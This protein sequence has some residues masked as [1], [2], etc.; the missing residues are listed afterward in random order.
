[1]SD[2][3][4][5]NFL[6]K[7]KDEWLNKHMNPALGE[8]EIMKLQQQAEEKFSLE[9][10]LANASNRANSRAIT[11]HPSK[12]SH[13]STGIGK[14]NHHNFT[15][16]TPIIS[17]R[18]RRADGFLRTGN[19]LSQTDSVGNA[20]ELDV[21]E[22]L[23]LKMQ[24]GDTLL[25]HIERESDLAKTILNNQSANY[26]NLRSGFLSIV[27]TQDLKPSTSS[28]IKQVYFPV[29]DNDYHLLSI[30]AN[31]GL[32]YA[33]RQRIDELRF[34]EKQ[35][36]LREL[37]RHHQF[38]ETGF[39]EI[40]DI[41]TIGYGGTKPQNIS[42]LNNQNGGKARLLRSVPPSLDHRHVQFPK[43]NFFKN[44]I[45][46]YHINEPLQ[47]LHQLFKTGL[48]STIPR[49]N[50][51]SGRDHRI[52]EILDRIIVQSHSVRTVAKDQYRQETCKLPLYQKIWL[53][54]EYQKERVE[55]DEWL[56]ELCEVISQWINNAYNKIITKAITL[57]PAEQEYIKTMI[58]T[59]REALR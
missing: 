6:Q 35:K 55:Q 46:F 1:M 39:L 30:L 33:L 16:V 2:S 21:D 40:Y 4:I 34:S 22:F 44:S 43:S 51:E 58:T 20:A 28:K 47:K 26:A 50:L 45:R 25:Q 17:N 13:P 9:N 48:D 41:T 7:R 52:E 29:R 57:G 8:N 10:W 15:Y 32:I 38:S 49:S 56:D 14:K 42:V 24:D 18:P 23:S 59:N 27:A 5:H 19:A 31:S 36:A 3:V 54:P 53:C 12:F 11:T 37:K